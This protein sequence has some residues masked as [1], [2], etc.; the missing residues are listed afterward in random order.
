[1]STDRIDQ[2]LTRHF[3][4][5]A[6]QDDR[7][8]AR[9]M[10]RLARP[11]PRQKIG[12]LGYLPPV[13][14]DWQFA[15]AWP[16]VAALAACAAFGFFIGIAGF[17]GRIDDARAQFSAPSDLSAVFDPEPLTGARP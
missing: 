7:A 4:G 8:G 9:V 2:L 17:D 11:L 12:L 14:L 13:L 16:R 3:A 1:M 5:D 6:T 10:M 15:P